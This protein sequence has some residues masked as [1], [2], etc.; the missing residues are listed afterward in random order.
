MEACYAVDFGTSNSLLSVCFENGEQ[1]LLNMDPKNLEDSHT[2]KSVFYTLDQKN[3]VY[4]SKAVEQYTENAAEGR[5]FRS[6]K[7]FLPE[8]SFKGTRIGNS[9]YSIEKLISIFLKEMKDRAD[10]ELGL[11][12]EKIMLGRPAVFSLVE[13]EHQLAI[14][15]LEKAAHMAGFKEVKF[16]PEPCSC[17]SI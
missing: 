17:E 5:L 6:I 8:E 7:K 15:R 1:K 12:V 9:F 11:N 10:K 16:C 2:L 14:D 13:S 3:W 4:G